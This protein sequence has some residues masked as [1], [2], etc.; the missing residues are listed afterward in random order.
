MSAPV[1]AVSPLPALPSRSASLEP[2]SPQA[3][4]P[5]SAPPYSHS[6]S[7]AAW[8]PRPRIGLILLVLLLDAALAVAGLFL[9]RAARGGADTG[10]AAAQPVERLDGGAGATDAA[11]SLEHVAPA[12]LPPSTSHA[13]QPGPLE[14]VVRPEPGHP[15]R[16]AHGD[17]RIDAGQ[18]V[19][20]TIDAHPPADA[21]VVDPPTPPPPSPPQEVPPAP[22]PIGPDDVVDEAPPP[23]DQP[24]DPYTAPDPS[25]T[26]DP[27]T[28]AYT[29]VQGD[30]R[31]VDI[32]L[33][34]MPT[35]GVRDGDF[36]R[37][38]ERSP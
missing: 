6:G 11:S 29:P 38:R 32:P 36:G 18:P 24:M 12:G 1:P 4:S 5:V 30:S 17:L 33:G 10:A 20:L 34:V 25:V 16:S 26:S 28:G 2:A 13:G 37:T 14:P 23:S 27:A 15:E 21:A 31:K 7:L 3:A 35:G 9:W 22:R 19:L 8:R